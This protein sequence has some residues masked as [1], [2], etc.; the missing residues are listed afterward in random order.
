LLSC[1]DPLRKLRS[2][3]LL[4]NAYIRLFECIC[5][6]ACAF[7]LSTVAITNDA[8]L[9]ANHRNIVRMPVLMRELWLE[10]WHDMHPDSKS[11]FVTKGLLHNLNS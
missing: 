4:A 10:M 5:L 8:L 2:F 9:T 1:R 7:P 11:K 6:C 3:C